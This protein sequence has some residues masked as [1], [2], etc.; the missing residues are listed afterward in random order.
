MPPMIDHRRIR[1][2]TY[3]Y[4]KKRLDKG[5]PIRLNQLYLDVAIELGGRKDLVDEF[6]E[7]NYK[8]GNI[9]IDKNQIINVTE[10][11]KNSQ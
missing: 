6:L 8:L 2:N 7:E 3:I 5:E 10:A 1:Q 9:T 11:Y 4:L